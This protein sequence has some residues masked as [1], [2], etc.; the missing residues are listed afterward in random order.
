MANEIVSDKTEKEKKDKPVFDEQTLAKVLEAA[1]VLQEHNRE[2]QAMELRSEPRARHAEAQPSASADQVPGARPETHLK[3]DYTAILAQIVETQHQIQLRHLDLEHAMSLIVER[4]VEITRGAGAAIGILDG[5][6]LRYRAAA[7]RMTP[8]VG[9]E[10]SMEKALCSASLRVGDVIRCADVNPE[11][12]IDAT[13][14]HRR[15]IQSLICVPIYHDGK[16]AG[17]VEVYYPHT[18]AFHEPDV[19]TCQLMAGLVTEALARSEEL[20]WKNSLASERAVMLEALEKLKPNLTA[21]V[22][23]AASRESLPTDGRAAVPAAP[24]FVCRKCGH[25]LVGEEQFCGQCGLPRSGDYQPSMQ[26]KVA[27][28]LQMQELAKK[29]GAFPTPAVP[30]PGASGPG[31]SGFGVPGPMNGASAGSASAADFSELSAERAL[32]D[33]IEREMPDLFR[34]LEVPR[35][36]TESDNAADAVDQASALMHE[37]EPDAALD[38]LLAPLGEEAQEAKDKDQEGQIE[39]EEQPSAE[40]AL[41]KRQRP[42]DWSSAAAA[43]EFLEQLAGSKRSNALVR[44]IAA[45][46]GDVYLMVAV[47]LV[48]CV[49]RWGIWSN[50]SVSATGTPPAA[51]AAHRRPSPEADLSVF[52]RMLIKM[53]LADPPEAPEYKGNPDTEVWIDLQHGLYYCPGS[54]LYSKTPRGKFATQRDAQLDQ[55]EP[56]YRKACD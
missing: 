22:D 5:R 28:M 20:S 30:I 39:E 53:G 25:E 36:R 29:N 54:D 45:R 31:T 4:V 40:T 56:A 16:T 42:S 47:I 33:S 35:E 3:D 10:V 38:S 7:G 19:H 41:A 17:G 27:S 24:A 8:A 2:L 11:F 18:N 34:L 50:H 15:G 1:Y 13:E 6:M 12:L 44:F 14:C 37:G 32:A 21:L 48:T 9:A 46:R 43:R 49:I 26:S 23:T 51:D 52:D 55:F